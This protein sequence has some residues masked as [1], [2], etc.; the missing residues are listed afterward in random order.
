M[1]PNE[2]PDEV[3][4]IDSNWDDEEDA[5]LL[6]NGNARRDHMGIADEGRGGK[7]LPFYQTRSRLVITGI[8]FVLIF[9]L[10]FG[11]LLMAVPSV[12][13]YEVCFRFGRFFGGGG[14]L[15][16]DGGGSMI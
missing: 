9:V 2:Y 7:A 16:V 12:R 14:F 11:G 1:A 15:Q 10:A 5:P 8:I 6:N 13:L 3:D 4:E